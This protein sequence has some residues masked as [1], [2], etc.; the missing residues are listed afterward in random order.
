MIFIWTFNE[1]LF[2]FGYVLVWYLHAGVTGQILDT[3]LNKR[4]QIT[5]SITLVSN[6]RIESMIM[7]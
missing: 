5:I 4:Q 3:F 6:F 2:H 7:G 1:Y